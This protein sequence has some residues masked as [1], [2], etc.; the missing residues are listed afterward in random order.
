MLKKSILVLVGYGYKTGFLILI[1][2]LELDLKGREKRWKCGKK[3]V[4]EIINNHE[5]S[6]RKKH[7]T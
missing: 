1:R 2:K 3:F 5:S 7:R 4:K 6:S